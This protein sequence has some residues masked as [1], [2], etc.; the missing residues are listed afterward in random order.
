MQIAVCLLL[1]FGLLSTLTSAAA[2]DPAKIGLVND[3]EVYVAYLPE[4]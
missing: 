4:L 3:T 2:A 1:G